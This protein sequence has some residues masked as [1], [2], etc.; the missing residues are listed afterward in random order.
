MKRIFTVL[1]LLASFYMQSHAQVLSNQCESSPCNALPICGT[2]TISQ[3]YAFTSVGNP[4]GTPLQITSCV[5][6]LGVNTAASNNWVFYR[7]T[8]Y[9]GGD[10]NFLITPNQTLTNLNW[11]LWDITTSGCGN[12]NTGNV[13]ECNFNASATA[14][15]GGITGCGATTSAIIEPSLTLTPGTYILGVQRP[16]GG[17][18]TTGFTINFAGTTADISEN[19]QPA[20]A[21]VLPITNCG[22][23]TTIKVLTSKP[24]KC[25]QV[26]AGDFAVTGASVVT[27]TPNNC[28]GCTNAVPNNTNTN[29]SNVKDTITLNFATGL[30]AGNHTLSLTANGVFSDICGNLASNAST[31]V[32]N[33]PAY[34]NDSI[35]QGYN[36]TTQTY[37]DTI[38]GT[39]GTAPY[40][41]K[42]TTNTTSPPPPANNGVYGAATNSFG[43]FSGLYGGVTYTLAVL[44]ANG[45]KDSTIITPAAIIPLGSPNLS[46]SQIISP[47]CYNQF[48]L[49]TIYATINAST[50]VGPYTWSLASSP[51]GVASTGA[52]TASVGN[53]RKW[54]G[55]SGFTSSAT[56]TITVRDSYGCTKTG[57]TQLIN[58]PQ[59]VL[60][61]LTSTNPLCFGDSSGTITCNNT[62]ASLGGTPGYTYV[63]NPTF[64]N[65]SQSG[66]SLNIFNNLPG[67]P[68]PGI[69]YTVTVQ[70]SKGCTATNSKAIISNAAIVIKTTNSPLPVT[71]VNPNCITPFGGSIKPTATGG[72]GSKKF[73]LYNST[74]TGFVDSTNNTTTPVY[75]TLSGLS[76]GTYTVMAKDAAGC[77]ATATYTLALPPIPD[78]VQDSLTNVLC[79]GACTGKA[80]TTTT[81]GTSPFTYAITPNNNAP[82][83]NA[84]AGTGVNV[85]DYSNLPTG[86]YTII[87][88]ST[89]ATT[90][91]GGCKDSV[92][93]FINQPPSAVS[94]TSVTKDSVQCFGQNNGLINVIATGGT[95]VITYKITP[96]GPQTNITGQ[97]TG[98]TA[99]C[100]TVTATD[101]NGCSITSSVCVG[102]PLVVNAI[103]TKTSDVSCFGLC[104]GT[105]KVKPTGGNGNFTY[106]VTGGSGTPLYNTTGDSCMI[107]NLCVGTYTILATDSKGCSKTTTLT[108]TQPTAITTVKSQ[109]NVS[110]F[111][112]CTGTAIITPSGG[113]GG[114]YNYFITSSP[115]GSSPTINASG[116]VGTLANL[117]SGTYI[118]ETKDSNACTKIDTFIITQPATALTATVSQGLPIT[119]NSVCNATGTVTP[120]G[121][122]PNYSYLIVNATGNIN[123]SGA[124]GNLTNLCADT[125]TVNVT[126]SKSCTTTV[127][128]TITQ[129]LPLVINTASSDSIACFG[130]ITGA[131]HFSVT[132]GTGAITY[133][134]NP[135]GP[136]SNTTGN[137]TGLAAGCYTVTAK[138]ANLCSITSSIC[139]GQPLLL[140]AN[141]F[142]IADATCN[143]Y[144]DGSGTVT[145]LNGNGNYTYVVT[146]PASATTAPTYNNAG[147]VCNLSSLC[148]GIYTINVTDSKGCTASTTL[149]IGQPNLVVPNYSTIQTPTCT[150]GCDGQAQ[151]SATGGNGIY[152]YISITPTTASISASGLATGLCA[153]TAYTVVVNDGNSC[154]GSVVI[155]LSTPAGPSALNIATQINP[156]C[157]PGCD[158]SASVLAIGGTGT[159]TYSIQSP[160]GSTCLPTQVIAGT[161]NNLGTG[162][163]TVIAAD[164]NN[165]TQS[166]I[167]TLVNPSAAA[168][169]VLSTTNASC[170][171]GCD[172]TATMNN[173]PNMVYTISPAVIPAIVGNNISGLCSGVSYT[174]TGTSS[175]NGCTSSTTAQIGTLSSP[176][177]PTVTSST[178]ASCNPGCDGTLV[179]NSAVALTYS[180]SP[181]GPIAIGNNV[182]GLCA[183]TTYTVTGADAAGCIVQTTIQVGVSP[184]PAAPTGVV[185]TNATCNPGCDGV[186]TMTPAIGLVYSVSPAPSIPILGN[187]I[188]GLCVGTTYTVTGTD[189]KGCTATA[190]ISVGQQTA[191]AISV[192]ST[193]NASCSPG[194]DGTAT[195]NNVPNMVYTI[196]PSVIPA[197]VGNNITGLCSGVLYTITGTS[198]LNGCTSTTTVQVG[199]VNGPAAPTVASSTPASCNPGCDGT[200]LFNSAVA[201][202]YSFSPTGPIAVGNNVSGL[203]AGTIYT[204]TATN[205]QGCTTTTTIQV[206][207]TSA[208]TISVS[209]TT[210]ASCNPGCDGTAIMTNVAGMNY[211][212]S[213]SV[214]PVIVGNTIS[215]LCAGTLYTIQGTDLAGCITTTTV[216]IGT[217]AS[218]TVSVTGLSN[219]T[220]SGSTNGTITVLGAAGTPGYTYSISPLTP[221][222]ITQ[223]PNGTFNGLDTLCYTIKVTDSKGCTGLTTQCIS[224]PPP[225]T[226]SF[227]KTDETCFGLNNGT[228]TATNTGG[229]PPYTVT[230]NGGSILTGLAPTNYLVVITDA[231]GASCSSNL[232]IAAGTQITMNAPAIAPPTCIPGCDGTIAITANSTTGTALTYQITPPAG[233]TCNTTQTSTGV[234]TNVGTGN[235][236]I[237]ATDLNGCSSTTNILMATP[238]NP[239][240]DSIKKSNL[241]CNNFC[242]GKITVYS[243]GIGYT[244]SKNNGVTFQN[245]NV[246]DS[247]CIGTYTVIVKSSYNCTVSTTVTLT[248][249]SP[250]VQVTSSFTSPSCYNQNNGTIT[251]I[252]SGGTGVIVDTITPNPIGSTQFP[253]GTFNNLPAGTYTVTARDSNLCAII[254]T[255]TLVN[256]PLLAWDNTS[257]TNITCF[258]ANNGKINVSVLGGTNPITYTINGNPGTAPFNN[259]SA[260]TYTIQATDAKGCSIT[261]SFTIVQPP[262]II[263]NLPVVT[264]N[265]CFGGSDGIINIT[266]TGG[267]PGFTYTLNPNNAAPNNTGI[268]NSLPTLPLPQV[269]TV[270]AVDASGCSITTTVSVSQPP[271]LVFSPISVQ[272]VA[273]FGGNTGTITAIANGGT[274]LLTNSNY[275]ILPTGSGV[276]TSPGFFT[277]LT[278]GSYT[279][280][281][282]DANNCVVSTAVTITQNPAIGIASFASTEPICNGDAN[283]SLSIAALGGVSPYV[284]YLDGGV[285]NSSGTFTGLIAKFYT[286]TIQD[287]LGCIKD[288][289]VQVT[290]PTAVGAKFVVTDASCIDSKDGKL[291]VTGTG[292]RGGYKYYVTPGLNINKSGIFSGLEAGTYTLRVVDTAGCEYT[293]MFTIN[294]PS[295]PLNSIITKQDLGCTGKGN[296]GQ[297]TANISGGTPPYTY[298]W[299]TNPAQT[300]PVATQLYFGS[301][302]L[303]VTDA[304]GCVIYDTVKIEAGPCCEIAFIPNAFSPNGD[305]KNDV[306]RVLSTAAIQV[307]QFDIYDRWGKRVWSTIDYRRGWDGTVDGEQA[308]LATYQYIFRYK[309][310]TDNNTYTIKRDVILVR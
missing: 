24:V 252:A 226:C 166:N 124:L 18:I 174:I 240:I 232:T 278:A 31:V 285:S 12:L 84:V 107:S 87:V 291:F 40:Q 216:Q 274:G 239:V 59:L 218:P 117:C 151:V 159:I 147:N 170:S 45:C 103:S 214:I 64:S 180:F 120:S 28:P 260:N 38:W 281:V 23:V 146:A 224:S 259:L 57:S 17:T 113:K 89:A 155:N 126:D 161:F 173:V 225:V 100:Y 53:F 244:Y 27:A 92:S 97:F 50:G 101:A 265:L 88:S 102:Q 198:N 176:A 8:C 129:P 61:A 49:D 293:N 16:T 241:S 251:F 246:F 222:T 171:P 98:L 109:V 99:Q 229:V 294:P 305:G 300:T 196:S 1:I 255:Y 150:P 288:T 306:F 19:T 231:N 179:F 199:T 54:Y 7:F 223:A 220:I 83:G 164:A 261:T 36:C 299:F 268:F 270:T 201:L 217:T 245:S 39:G 33:V 228:I 90:L 82:C 13:V 68:T 148:A 4:P 52:S 191:P 205:A 230:A 297:A 42:I 118:V 250:V 221:G 296:E 73:Y 122:T 271:A 178:V 292:G 156:S 215:G 77:T 266:A 263:Y 276:Q 175:V 303:Q 143:G 289:I 44:D 96:L 209:T 182:T 79:F 48:S 132:G 257:S 135:S 181:M 130:L 110:C 193:T 248:Q 227:S 207:A 310:L 104:D 273:C 280:N 237:T 9:S 203:C 62:F 106:I 177:A 302:N 29:Y 158:G 149:L 35:K 212:I 286:I 41:Y 95:G 131:V 267:N 5:N 142:K 34:L 69:T 238:G 139:V 213:P 243:T 80:F 145:P 301:Y 185:T 55:L 183:G 51:A 160:V 200:L 37:I 46:A 15:N 91:G 283:G 3:P 169:S 72:Q 236:V 287:A 262:A 123:S 105:G 211:A 282:T 86:N 134:I 75:G 14:A 192:F 298:V 208:S 264:N 137:F 66:P 249:P 26:S 194:C 116:T 153:G 10:L 121:G 125:Y 197:I 133:T 279:I 20:L 195:M 136:S 65:T 172:G 190:T 152:T 144:C 206:S 304:N 202:T 21:T 115:L 233:S 93:F 128:L 184:N 284:Y 30:S 74:M 60:P 163:Y 140:T 242:N 56:F 67:V 127:T 188:G 234:F 78:L 187:V 256:P 11:A 63:I 111:G 210:G 168:I 204:V 275:T 81:G 247:L 157:L 277:G 307:Q 6:N 235:Y 165:C 253:A 22:P 308:P 70:D 254:Q 119:C 309:C 58:P 167:F 189:N 219:V 85:G 76:A 112:Q 272:N 186:V 162:T 94:I 290:E 295:N 138:D 2:A 32:F 71:F 258:G 47:P 108:I 25:A 141:S 269:Y 114:F 154:S 43:V